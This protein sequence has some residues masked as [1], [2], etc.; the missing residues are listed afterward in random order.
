MDYYNL[1]LDKS[2]SDADR[3]HTVKIGAQY[4]LPVGRGRHFGDNINRVADFAIG[5]W[6]LQYI[7]NY[8]S[9]WP[10]SL[11]ATGTPNSNF[12]TNR[13]LV[14]NPSGASLSTG[15]SPDFNTPYI[16]TSL[17]IDPSKVNR[18]LRGN[19]SAYLSQLRSPWVLSDDFSLQKNFHPFGENRMRVQFRAEFLNLFNRHHWGS[20]E[21]NASSNLFGQ[22]TGLSD[23]FDPRK[24]QFGLRADW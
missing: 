3:T 1:A 17:F 16:N 7:G 6:N 15:V 21:T 8:T 22:V 5:G 4:D 12:A 19:A 23:W 18:Y 14:N 13:P 10:L 9:G 11:G 20:F 24:I 2:I